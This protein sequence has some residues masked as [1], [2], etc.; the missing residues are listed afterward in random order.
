MQIICFQSPCD[1]SIIFWIDYD[2]N[3]SIW[4]QQH[5]KRLCG[6]IN[7]NEVKKQKTF[8]FE[9]T[10]EGYAEGNFNP[11]AW[12][13]WKGILLAHSDREKE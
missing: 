8:P 13:K 6:G 7:D 11:V 5:E 2:R 12:S 1:L 9:F 4:Q 3:P 10:S